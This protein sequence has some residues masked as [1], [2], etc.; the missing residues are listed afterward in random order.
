[1]RV[2][3]PRLIIQYIC[4]YSPNVE[5]VSF[6]GNLRTRQ[7][8]VIRAARNMTL[9]KSL[10]SRCQEADMWPIKIHNKF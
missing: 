1:M 9:A 7:A 6:I 10:L 3:C 8:V 4:S 5:A 2:G